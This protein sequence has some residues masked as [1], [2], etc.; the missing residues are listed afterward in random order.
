M[1]N[2]GCDG[3]N[4]STVK[5]LKAGIYNIHENII[6]WTKNRQDAQR[7]TVFHNNDYSSIWSIP[8]DYFK[9]HFK[10]DRESK[11]Y[12]TRKTYKDIEQ[13]LTVIDHRSK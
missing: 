1:R 8:S 11:R 9:E 5:F 6:F 13:Y 4:M 7:K 10:Y 2:L 3:E 12:E